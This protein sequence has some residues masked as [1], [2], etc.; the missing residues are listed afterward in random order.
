MLIDENDDDIPVGSSHESDPLAV[1]AFLEQDSFGLV[2]EEEVEDEDED[3]DSGQEVRG[4]SGE[5]PFSSWPVGCCPL[6]D[7]E[8]LPSL[9]SSLKRSLCLIVSLSAFI[10]SSGE[11]R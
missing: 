5:P 3:E 6:L 1:C 8:L 2:D 4:N 11:E 9:S 7:F 10:S